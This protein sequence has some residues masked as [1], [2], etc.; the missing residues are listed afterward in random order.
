MLRHMR[1]IAAYWRGHRAHIAVLLVLTLVSSGVALGFPLVFRYVLD[2]LGPVLAGGSRLRQV[3]A[4]LAALAL[5]RFVAGLYPGARAWLNSKIGLDVRDRVFDSLKEKDYRFW[6]RFRPGDLTTRLTDDIVEYPRIGWFSCSAVFRALESSARLLFCLAV[7]VLIS[8]ELTLLAVVPLPLML[9]IFYRVEHRLGRKVE[10]SRRA[11]S[12]TNDLLDS[13]FAG[14]SIVKAYGAE[15][16]QKSRLRRLLDRR[17]DIEMDIARLMMLVHSLYNFIGHFGKVLVVLVGGIL[18]IR[19]RIGLGDFYAFY[20]Y[21]DLLLA[22]MMDIPNLFVTSRQAF[23]SIDREVEILDFPGRKRRLEGEDPGPIGC[24]ELREAGFAYPEGPGL[25]G[26][27][28]RVEAPAVVAVVGEVGSGKSTLLKMLAGLLPPQEGEVLYNGVPLQRTEEGALAGRLGYVPQESVLFS[29][30]VAE[31]V[32]L[33]RSI[34]EERVAL[35]LGTAG[36]PADELHLGARRLLGQGGTGV[37]GGQR[38]R[39][40]I[41]R[42][43]AGDPSLLLLDDCTAALDAEREEALWRRLGPAASGAITF[44]VTHREATVRHADTV[45]LLH[46]GRVEAYGPHEV[47]LRKSSLYRYVLSTGAAGQGA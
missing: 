16:G 4:V 36:L 31:N 45:L 12:H 22:P 3:M 7:M 18:V 46:R 42:A 13:T 15:K 14:I 17:V 34:G 28:L 43:L 11:T 41:A 47:L 35:A 23:A 33:G 44:V 24:V 27:S 10:E 20:V 19:E 26:V 29:E 25:C 9:Y 6:G 40:A 32:R 21:L 1:W 37:S 2:N 39:V 38:Q 30:T 8:W 5:G